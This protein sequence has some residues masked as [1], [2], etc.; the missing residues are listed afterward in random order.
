[1]GYLRTHWV[2]RQALAW[3][4]WVNFALLCLVINLVEPF[5]RPLHPDGSWFSIILAITYLIVGHL[6]IYPWQVIG[7]VRACNRHLKQS[8]DSVIVTAAQLAIG[9][10]LIIG[11]VTMSTTLQ[12]I[13]GTPPKTALEL[14]RLDADARIPGYNVE[15]IAERSLIRINGEFA[16]GL[17]GDLEK[18]LAEEPA[19]HGIVLNSDGGRIFEARG[20]ARLIGERRMATYVYRMCQSACVTAF[21]AGSIR[22][23]GEQGRLGFHQY[24]LKAIHPFIDI[25]DEQEKDRAFYRSRG[26]APDLLARI[27]TTPHDRMWYPTPDELLDANV[28]HRLI[29]HEAM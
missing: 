22:H 7:L 27:F 20:V 14:A 23:L 26:I 4:F 3:S 5:I 16:N 8:S 9:A 24:R 6:L 12:S 13:F 17:T 10:S 28:V 1:M 25:V 2:G 18:L 19:V 21:I 29:Q 11:L 15:L